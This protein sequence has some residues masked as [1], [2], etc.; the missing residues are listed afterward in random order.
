MLSS[1]SFLSI[2]L[3]KGIA[4]V[5]RELFVKICLFVHWRPQFDI[6]VD[7]GSGQDR[8]VRMRLQTIDNVVIRLQQHTQPGGVPLPYEHVTAV[9]A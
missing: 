2:L 5:F 7:A 9:T 1:R 3:D 4:Y 8:Q 6:V